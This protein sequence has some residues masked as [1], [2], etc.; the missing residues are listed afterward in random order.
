MNIYLI[1]H[2]QV[3]SNL[4]EIN[5]NSRKQEGLTIEGKKQAE[6]LAKKLSRLKIDKVF[7]SKS[8]R[9]LETIRPFLDISGAD[10]SVDAR[11]NEG[12]F[13]IFNGLTLKEAERKYP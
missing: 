6:K 11:L 10:Y 4:L 5:F 7:V 2:A 3:A 13:G 9:S 1:R 12:N 8:R